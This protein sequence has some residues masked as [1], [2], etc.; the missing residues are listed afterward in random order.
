[1]NH[2]EKIAYLKGLMDGLKLDEQSDTAKLFAAVTDVLA[3]LSEAVDDIDTGL[4]EL[5]DQV[6]EID[7]DLGD[8]EEWVYSDDEEDEDDDCDCC[9]CCEC[10]SVT[11]P[12]CG[13]EF[14]LDDCDLDDG[15]V[16]C[17]NCNE[18]LE[19]DFDEDCDCCCGDDCDCNE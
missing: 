11:C 4:C 14:E 5:S 7:E 12:N 8:L 2:A 17:P 6:D 9:D 3:S 16:F 15:E 10:Y 19:F 18:K 1:M 13:E